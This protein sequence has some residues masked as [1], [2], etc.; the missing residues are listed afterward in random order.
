MIKFNHTTDQPGPPYRLVIEVRWLVVGS[1]G[2]NYEN[3]KFYDLCVYDSSGD[4][5][6][7]EGYETVEEAKAAFLR[8]PLSILPVG[9]EFNASG[10]KVGD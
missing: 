3:D 6:H 8:L 9:G 7:N 2:K 10:A 5:C 4:V 1:I